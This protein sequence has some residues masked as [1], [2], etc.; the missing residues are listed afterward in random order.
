M[1]KGKCVIE[2]INVKKSRSAFLGIPA[3]KSCWIR[4]WYQLPF[5]VSYQVIVWPP[6]PL[7]PGGWTS[8]LKLYFQKGELDRISI[9]RRGWPFS[10]GGLQ[11]LQE[12][13]TEISFIC[14]FFLLLL[15]L[16]KQTITCSELPKIYWRYTGAKCETCSKLTTK[17]PEQLQWRRY[18][19]FIVNFVNLSYL[20]LSVSI[21]NIEQVMACNGESHAT[22]TKYSGVRLPTGSD[23]FINRPLHQLYLVK[24]NTVY[25][26][27]G[28]L[29]SLMKPIWA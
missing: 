22:L 23:F 15:L 12:K 28:S 26:G 8:K 18:G 7:Y 2:N 3:W 20:L 10:G 1:K 27:S 25:S 29:P 9:L 21:V 5:I 14:V 16:T 6:P 24:S 19:V 4:H 11:F 13:L 17:T